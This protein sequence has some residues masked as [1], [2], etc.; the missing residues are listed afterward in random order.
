MQS[1]PTRH[2]QLPRELA[3]AALDVNSAVIA[4]YARLTDDYNPIH[5]DPD[6][7]VTTPMGGII[8]H[9]MLSMNLIWQALARTLGPAGRERMEIRVR[10]TRPVRLGDTVTA[11]GRL[12]PDASAACYE[13]WVQNQAGDRVI[14]GTAQAITGGAGEMVAK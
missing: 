9:G 7:A 6:F 12:M 10:F 2:D 8:A 4:H 5:V 13:V 11:G 3:P 1:Q 14:V